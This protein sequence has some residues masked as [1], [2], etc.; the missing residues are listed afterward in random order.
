M[1][2]ELIKIIGKAIIDVITVIMQ[3]G[4]ENNGDQ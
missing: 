3:K 2:E 4:E 1:K